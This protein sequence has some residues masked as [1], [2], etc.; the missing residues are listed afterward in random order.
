MKGRTMKAKGTKKTLKAVAAAVGVAAVLFVP[1]GC[2]LTVA[3]G[4][5]G[6]SGG[7]LGGILP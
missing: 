1:T 3:P 5:G 7:I 2:T 6:G 4:T